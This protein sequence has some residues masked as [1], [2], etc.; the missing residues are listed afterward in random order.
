MLPIPQLNIDLGA[1]TANYRLLRDKTSPAELGAAVKANAYG[2]GM[3]PIL[4]TLHKAG[5]RFFFTAYVSEAA[6]LRDTLP[7]VTVAPLHSLVP[8]QYPGAY[9]YNITPVLNSLGEIESWTKFARE[10]NKKLA[11]YIHLDTGM[12]RLGLPPDEQEKLIT[13]PTLLNGITV[14]AWLSHFACSDELGK[15]MTSQQRDLFKNQLAR[16]PKAP[17]SICNSSGIFWGKDYLFDLVRTGVALYG[18]NP[19]P[20][21]PNPMR[22]V[23]EL[24]APILQIRHV[25]SDMTVG[26]GAS[27]RIARKGRIATLALGYADGYHRALSGKGQVKIGQ[28]LAP[29]VGRISMDLITVDVTDVPESDAHVGVFAT[30]IGKHRPVDM[31]AEESG[32]IGYEILT[33]LGSRFQRNY[34]GATGA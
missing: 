11:A 15:P 13:N 12:N 27:H 23:V 3:T 25:D 7:D 21:K 18:V 32:T 30:V 26:Y 20:G 19:T 22:D 1:L 17:A 10:K 14:K 8:E 24:S 4:H 9:N 33:S 28:H 29:I 6:Q 31:V 16:L 34:I 2:L 5:C